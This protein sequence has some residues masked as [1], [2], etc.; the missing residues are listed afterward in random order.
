MC[1]SVST[2]YSATTAEPSCLTH[3]GAGKGCAGSSPPSTRGERSPQNPP[4]PAPVA[5]STTTSPCLAFPEQFDGSP[6]KCKG[7]LLQCSM[8]VN[9]QPM[10]YSTDDSRIAFVCSLL[11]GRA[12]EWAI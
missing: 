6:T 4:P 2:S 3:G 8:F 1:S 9:Q 11:T 10:L 7:F 5:A 12:L